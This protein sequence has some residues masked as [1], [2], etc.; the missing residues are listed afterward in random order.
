MLK[1]PIPQKA[2]VTEIHRPITQK[3]RS[4]NDAHNER[5]VREQARPGTLADFPVLFQL[6]VT[7]RVPMMVHDM[8]V[9]RQVR[10]DDTC[11]RCPRCQVLL[12]REF[13][14][15]CSR[16]G[17]A[18]NW[19]DYRKAKQTIVEC[20][21]EYRIERSAALTVRELTKRLSRE[22]AQRSQQRFGA[23]RYGS[24]IRRGW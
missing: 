18:L 5:A 2:S 13:M 22:M 11:Y 12:E 3:E 7:Y 24:Q 10:D 6:L 9:F 14:E 19:R 20:K 16:C 15:Y 8:V 23:N 21:E 4:P 17:Q 1:T